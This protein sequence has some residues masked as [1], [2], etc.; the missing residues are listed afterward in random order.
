MKKLIFT[1]ITLFTLSS[2]LITLFAQTNVSGGIYTNAT[3]TLNNSPY[4][5]TDTVVVF[6]G[7]TLTIEPGVTV[8]FD[9]TKFIE[10]RSAKLIAIGTNVDS[11]TFTSNSNSPFIGIF[12][13]IKFTA[14]NDSCI[15]NYCDF[16]F[17]D[18]ALMG[19]SNGPYLLV[20]NSNFQLN[21]NGIYD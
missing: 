8:K 20:H 2:S 10:I 15:L 1:L 5:I 12:E 13:G 3:W 9:D 14:A 17:A 19:T 4:I 16:S 11:I 18:N 6:P 21:S 7:I